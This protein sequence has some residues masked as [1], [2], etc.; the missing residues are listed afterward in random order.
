MKNLVK[1]TLKFTQSGGKND[2]GED[3]KYKY[4]RYL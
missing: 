1:Y 4:L 3:N 2:E